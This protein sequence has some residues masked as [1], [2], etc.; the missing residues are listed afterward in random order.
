MSKENCLKQNGEVTCH[1]C[2][3]FTHSLNLLKNNVKYQQLLD[4]LKAGKCPTGYL[5]NIE[6]ETSKDGETKITKIEGMIY[7]TDQV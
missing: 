6:T 5:P 2:P 3:V 4:Y 1:G 7:Q